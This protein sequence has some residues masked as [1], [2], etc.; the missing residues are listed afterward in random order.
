MDKLKVNDFVEVNISYSLNTVS[1]FAK[2]TGD[3]NPI[4]IDPKFAETTV[5]KKTHRT[6]SFANKYFLKNLSIGFTGSRNNISWPGYE[7]SSPSIS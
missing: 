3:N 6:W 5:F 7:I 1:E 2:V 4:H